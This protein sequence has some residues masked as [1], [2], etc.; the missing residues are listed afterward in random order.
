MSSRRRPSSRSFGI[1]CWLLLAASLVAFAAFLFTGQR[2]ARAVRAR[3][4]SPAAQ[5]AGAREILHAV[6]YPA[7]YEPTLSLTVPLLGR[8][9][10]LEDAGAGVF[11][12]GLFLYLDGRRSDDAAG[13]SQDLAGLLG[14]RGLALT[15]AAPL[16]E[17]RLTVGGQELDYRS[18]RTTVVTRPHGSHPVLAALVEVRCRNSTRAGGVGAWIA[19]DPTPWVPAD[20]LDLRGTPAD[21]EAIRAFL[22]GFRFCSR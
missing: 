7:G 18:L 20:Q 15:P 19:A 13:T 8:V 21:P 16:V 9:V 14:L 1:G 6:S 2:L 22:A 17:G 10:V 3:L 5:V 4:S 11:P 12:R